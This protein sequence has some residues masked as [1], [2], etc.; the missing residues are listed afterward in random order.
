MIADPQPA[1]GRPQPAWFRWLPVAYC[2]LLAALAALPL[3]ADPGFLNTRGIGDSPFLLFRVQ[4]LVSALVAGEFPVRWMA[5]AA[6]GYGLPHYSYYASS[7]VH[8]AAGLKLLGFSYTAAI[9]LTQWLALLGAA[10]AVYG[11]LNASGYPR[12]QS[13]LGAAAYT[14][15]P[16]HLVNLYIR[17]DSLA[18]LWAMTLYPLCLWAARRL[19]DRPSPGRALAL[20]AAVGGLIL[21]HNISALNFMP[22]LGLYLLLT[23]RGWRAIGWG[24][25]AVGWGLALAA[26][27]WAPAL[28][29]G[30]AVQ[31]GDLTQGFFFFGN[32]FRGAD[33]LNPGWWFDYAAQ[34]FSLGRV[35]AALA[36]L[37]LARLVWRRSPETPLAFL[38]TGLLLA[39]L[40]I[41]P[42]SKPVWE[43]VPLVAYTQFPWRFLSIQA[44]FTAALTASAVG[45]WGSPPTLRTAAAGAA[46]IGLLAASVLA[47]LKLEFFP[48]NDADV[49]A[50]RLN[51]YEYLTTAIGTTVNSE[52]LPQAVR[53]R[54]FTSA[55][56]LGRAAAP[57][58]LA[59]AA[60]G[61]R[62]WKR[63]AR[64]AWSITVT[65]A[66]G[67]T[68]AV[69][70]HFW[71]G[72]RA[73]A[74]GQAL[75]VQ[76]APSLGW[77]SFDLPP[78][79]HTVTLWLDRTPLRATAEAVSAL[80][81]LIPAAIGLR[82]RRAP[83]PRLPRRGW[84]A[85]G[86]L[87]LGL[88]LARLLL[89]PQT[90]SGPLNAD[91]DALAYPHHAVVRFAEGTELR[92]V[93]Y[94]AEAVRPGQ[95]LLVTTT[96]QTVR[97]DQAR[98]TLTTPAARAIGHGQ[99]VATAAVPLAPGLHTLTTPLALPAALTPGLYLVS[100]EVMAEG[101]W[102]AAL[103]STGRA[104]GLVYLAPVRVDNAPQPASAQPRQA[105]GPLAVI[106]A[107]PR[108]V[109]GWLAVDLVWQADAEP[110]RSYPVT[111]RLR[112]AAGNTLASADAQT[113]AGFYPTTL[114][115]PG[116]AVSETAWLA[117]PEGL[118]PATYTVELA[119]YDPLS[120]EALGPALTTPATLHQP[121]P[122]R[123]AP[124]WPLTPALALAEVAAPAEVAQGETLTLLT[125]W[126]TA[127]PLP[128]GLE[129]EWTLTAAAPS[130]AAYT[131]RQ[132]LAPGSDPRAWAAPQT[133]LG[134]ALLS[135]PNSLPIG[136]YALWVRLRTEAGA[137]F[138]SPARVGAITVTRQARSFDLPA[139]LTPL[140]ATFDGQLAL[141][142]FSTAQT[143]EAVDLTL[144]FRALTPPRG[145]Y[146]YFVHLFDPAAEIIVAQ[147]D[148]MPRAFTYP[149]SR[150]AAKEVVVETARLS[151]AEAAPGRYRLAIGWYDPATPE[152]ARLPAFDAQG[153]PQENGRVLLPVEITRP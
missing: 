32:H 35:Q 122:A 143:G 5:E 8:V 16:I 77:V 83:L 49:T 148:A 92:A 126:V 29:E 40:M 18:E 69:P 89:P 127:A 119:P 12:A 88:A 105:F 66:A 111:V 86:L 63:G 120:L 34:P 10:G 24:A 108:Q 22:F 78:G 150:W 57:K 65:D 6:Y 146:K 20:A 67:A 70:I 23:G 137:A 98:L 114:W 81:L 104:R 118:P 48:L 53:P 80:A 41:T 109:G 55:A 152:L 71:P 58:A 43:A 68:V 116:E 19:L 97:A 142:A 42:L 38:L 125:A 130:A 14:F 4:Q 61:A 17:G 117:L 107:A 145:D 56:L 90:P 133:Y 110:G 15:A 93:A 50:D 132:P 72:W 51:L 141:A 96:W 39:T 136:P 135:L 7:A 99:P 112:D 84:A 45:A 91:F 115:R 27:F 3:F 44:L 60:S 1:V 95:T 47:P 52:Y 87:A 153:Q 151:L 59:G 147:V 129:A 21:T 103:T 2:L 37:G 123:A 140:D 134:R 113:G 79:A 25:A 124:A 94:E 31:L 102:Q 128:A 76:A 85:A 46:L 121:A 11:W 82:R 138:G 149:T 131:A 106:S 9:K 33:L 74:N 101:R 30:A 144:A 139:G 75:T 100:V 54:P 28:M 13:A 64:E 26:F 36:L 73:E 62:L